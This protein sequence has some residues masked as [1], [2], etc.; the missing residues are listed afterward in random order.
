M[1]LFS[2]DMATPSMA[3]QCQR[4][5]FTKLLQL[6]Q[7]T[8]LSKLINSLSKLHQAPSKVLAQ[9]DGSTFVVQGLVNI[10]ALEIDHLLEGVLLAHEGLY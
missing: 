2:N 5:G 4:K 1:S 9:P 10:P 8:D 3:K 6:L 7:N